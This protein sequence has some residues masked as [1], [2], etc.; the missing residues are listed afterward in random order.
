MNIIL[1]GFKKSG[2]TTIGK[3]L[4]KSLKKNFIDIDDVIKKLF[5]KQYNE[6]KRIFEI[7]QFLKEKKF[8]ELETS[9]F[10]EIKDIA[11]AVIATSGGCVLNKNNLKALKNPKIIIYLKAGKE[12]L[13]ERI[14]SGEKSIFSSSDLFERQYDIR[15]FL[16]EN[17]CDFIIETD[18]EDFVKLSKQII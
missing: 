6:K 3:I 5:E 2:K 7:Y 12:A 10:E 8:R 17:S 13:K 15:K 18:R 14:Q 9:A 4:S 16:Y 1:I 11:D